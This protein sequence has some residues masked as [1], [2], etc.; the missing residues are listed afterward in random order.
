MRFNTKGLYLRWFL[1]FGAAEIVT[2]VLFYLNSFIIEYNRFTEG[3][4][5]VRFFADDLIHFLIPALSGAIALIGFEYGGARSTLVGC[6]PLALTRLIYTLPY[7]YL[8]HVYMGFD[9]IEAL[10]ASLV[11]SVL[12]AVITYLWVL[13]LAFVSRLCLKR[14]CVRVGILPT[15]ALGADA[16]LDMSSPA[17]ASI[18]AIAF[19]GFT[20]ELI[21][22]IINTVNYL[23]EYADS[24]RMSEIVYIVICFVF[25]AAKLIISHLLMSYVRR[26]TIKRRA[27]KI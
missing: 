13:L 26:L 7:Y 12:I 23:I 27:I 25:L 6:I 19:I 10:L 14:M 9:S 11:I 3:I 20:A 22:E 16:L 17:V 2:F 4:E 5:Y 15:E 21:E 1:I 8:Y 24:Y 18:A